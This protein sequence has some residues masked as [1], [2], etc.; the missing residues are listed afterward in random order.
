MTLDEAV[1]KV[2]EEFGIDPACCAVCR[3]D[4]NDLMAA[5]KNVALAATALQ[6]HEYFAEGGN[7]MT[8][9][10]NRPTLG[11]YWHSASCKRCFAEAEINR[12]L[13]K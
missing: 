7:H 5:V 11:D 1:A 6:E 10:E 13:G 9:S 12:L 2:K 4:Y 3:A 8:S